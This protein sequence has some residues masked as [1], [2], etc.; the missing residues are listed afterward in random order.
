M[1]RTITIILPALLFV[2]SMA[3]MF[4]AEKIDEPVVVNVTNISNLDMPDN[5][6]S[7]LDKSCMGCHNNESKST[8]GKMKLN[9]DKFNDGKYS[10][11]KQIAKLNAI[12][13][14][15]AKGKMPP[16]KFIAKNPDRALSADDTKTLSEWAKAQASTL[17][18]E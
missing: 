14:T 7:I 5:I 13:K 1:K 6:K 10:K 17:A 18:G 3:F 11:G 4:D 16:K 15:L 12:V 8:K 9:F 2:F